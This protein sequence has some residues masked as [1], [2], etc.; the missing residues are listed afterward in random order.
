MGRHGTIIDYL[1]AKEWFGNPKAKVKSINSDNIWKENLFL[2]LRNL[3]V[4]LNIFK[5]EL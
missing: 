2:R 5:W 4:F 1:G 3:R